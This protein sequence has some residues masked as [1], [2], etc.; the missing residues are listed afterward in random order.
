M[1][2]ADWDRVLAKLEAMTRERDEAQAQADAWRGKFARLE[3]ERASCCVEME[4]ERDEARALLR[5][6]REA[7]DVTQDLMLRTDAALEG[8][9]G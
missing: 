9:D 5:E 1:S 4:R 8:R 6:W 7:D 3:T 2:S